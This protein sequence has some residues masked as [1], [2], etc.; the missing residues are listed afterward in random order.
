MKTTSGP[1]TET[2][3]TKCHQTKLDTE[4]YTDPGKS[5]GL[6]SWCKSCSKDGALAS[7]KR[8][9]E[10]M[11]D[12]AWKADKAEYMRQ[13]RN[14]PEGRTETQYMNWSRRWIAQQLKDRYPDEWEALRLEAK[15]AWAKRP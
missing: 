8:R 6:H 5:N 13:R 1:T 9:R 11:G 12:D 14:T 10:S 3:C 7:I 4:F 2:Q 15:S